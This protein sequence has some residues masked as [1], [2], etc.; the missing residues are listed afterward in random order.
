MKRLAAPQNGIIWKR[1]RNAFARLL[2]DMLRAG[3]IA[4]PFDK[5]PQD[6][7]LPKF[8]PEATYLFNRHEFPTRGASPGA[9]STIVL[10]SHDL[11]P[12]PITAS[13]RRRP[14]FRLRHRL[15]VPSRGGYKA[16]P[17]WP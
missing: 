13:D 9:L 17:R 10:A 5:M 7:P 2:L 6:G 14:C 11:N 4:E 12:P 1:N 16:A 15:L 8:N 3:R